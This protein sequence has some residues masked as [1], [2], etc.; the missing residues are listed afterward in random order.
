MLGKICSNNSNAPL[1][2]RPELLLHPNIPKPLHGIS[3]RVIKGQTWWD[4]TR[5]EAYKANNYCCWACGIHRNAAREK[6]WLEAHE[7]YE[8]NYYL[9]E[10]KLIEIVALCH[11]C[12]NFIHDGRMKMMVDRGEMTR[13]RMEEILV[14]GENILK[15]AK[16]TKSSP[17][18]LK[19]LAARWDEYYLLFEGKK[20]Y[21]KFKNY[22]E[23]YEFYNK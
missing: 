21:S 16:L 20:Y 8:I 5:Q 2:V 22:E 7:A 9:G 15:L 10:V 23:W 19:G 11:F 13:R 3:P 17:L 6:K 4:K 1:F 18:V 14:H 12:H